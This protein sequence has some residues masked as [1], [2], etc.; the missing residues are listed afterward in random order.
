[1]SMSQDESSI[2]NFDGISYLHG[3]LCNDTNMNS[4]IGA[5]I[6]YIIP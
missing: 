5:G 3:T 6:T 2:F 1:M 4:D